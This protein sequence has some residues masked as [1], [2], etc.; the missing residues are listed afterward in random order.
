MIISA[1]VGDSWRLMLRLHNIYEDVKLMLVPQ[2]DVGASQNWQQQVKTTFQQ[3]WG[4]V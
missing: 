4:W 3:K 1:K 2:E